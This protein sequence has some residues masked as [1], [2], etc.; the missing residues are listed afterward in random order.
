MKYFVAFFL[1]N[2]SIHAQTSVTKALFYNLPIDKTKADVVDS[3]KS[4]TVLFHVVND[5]YSKNRFL[6]SVQKNPENLPKP[7]ILPTLNVIGAQFYRDT[8]LTKSYYTFILHLTYKR[9]FGSFKNAKK[10]FSTIVKTIENEYRIKSDSDLFDG[11]KTTFM[12]SENENMRCSVEISYTGILKNHK[13]D[14]TK[15]SVKVTYRLNGN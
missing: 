12:D 5:F 3:I 2:L 7:F 1:F 15:C 14:K 13:Q 6:V 11:N 4:D 9:Q 10:A 8:V